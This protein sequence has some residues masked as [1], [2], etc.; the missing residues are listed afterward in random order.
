[1]NLT[2]PLQLFPG[3]YWLVFNPKLDFNFAGGWGRQPSD[4]TNGYV[5]Q[6]IEPGGG[7]PPLPTVW[8]S[9]QDIDWTE[10]YLPNIV[11]PLQDFA[12][13]LQGTALD[14]NIAV[15]KT[16]IDF[17]EELVGLT[18]GGQTVT[19]SNTGTTDLH[20]TSITIT[21]GS[22][23][24]FNVASGATNGCTLTNQTLA[25]DGSC[26]V[27]VT[28]SPSASGAQSATL[29]IASDDPDTA[30][31]EVALSGTGVQEVVPSVTEGTVGT[32]IT[33][34]AD[35]S[36]SFGGKKGKVLI[37]RNK[38]KSVAKIAKGGWLRNTITCTVNKALP[39]G[40]YDVKIMLQPYKDG[41][42]I[43]IPGGFTY[44]KPEIELPL[45]DSEGAKGDL[46]T[47]TGNFFGNKNRKFI[48]IQKC[49][50]R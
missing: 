17:G 18:S 35:P 34:T 39:A 25:P 8:T 49:K 33:F 15:D 11:A 50:R 41:V 19:I 20:I 45:A 43:D 36:V 30:A 46:V 29:A 47:L 26:T 16:T 22:A 38:V 21:G 31:A 9:V 5:A 2:E 40:T 1:M 37:Q 44:K 13:T 28:F 32:E 14:P 7:D 10:F 4:T 27:S 42:S 12:F 6:F 23:G 3:T 48:C 24:M